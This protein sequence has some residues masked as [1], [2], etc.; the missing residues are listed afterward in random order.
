MRV[1]GACDTWIVS[2]LNHSHLSIESG[3]PADG[4]L[5]RRELEGV[6]EHDTTRLGEVY[7]GLRS[8]LGRREIADALGVRTDGFVSNY[9][10]MIA[11]LLDGV[12]PSSPS[13]GGQVRTALASL[14]QNTEVALSPEARAVFSDRVSYLTA[15]FPRR[16]DPRQPPQRDS[17]GTSTGATPDLSG[18]PQIDWNLVSR[19]VRWNPS[20][21]TLVARSIPADR[22][23]DIRSHAEHRISRRK[24]GPRIELQHRLSEPESENVGDVWIR[25]AQG[26]AGSGSHGVKQFRN[27]ATTTAQKR[28]LQELAEKRSESVSSILSELLRQY[29]ERGSAYQAT[30]PD[31]SFNFNVDVDLWERAAARAKLQDTSLSEV[32]RF[33]VARLIS[34]EVD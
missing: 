31:D 21:W 3:G 11:A 9:R 1:R 14:L 10:A 28:L 23:D 26:F 34:D 30:K 2:D 33:E 20:D 4:Q 12:M 7:R 8:G 32:M 16:P 22:F 5:I 24:N 29:V 27:L 6:L 19:A 18:L 17:V 15:T 13:M 25:Q